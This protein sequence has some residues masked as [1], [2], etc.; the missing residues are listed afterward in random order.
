MAAWS[1]AGRYALAPVPSPFPLSRGLPA[2]LPAARNVIYIACT[3]NGQIAYVGSTIRTIQ[4][5]VREHVH[6]RDR[7]Q[8]WDRL[9]VI[10][11]KEDTPP[12]LVRLIEGRVGRLLRPTSTIRLPRS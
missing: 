9:W 10:T 4:A 1:T 5:R 7:G 3:C 6:R 8:G 11:L 12:N 2:T